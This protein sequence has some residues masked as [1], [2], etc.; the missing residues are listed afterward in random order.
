MKY[1]HF[2]KE[3]IKNNT[4]INYLK[5]IINIQSDQAFAEAIQIS[6]K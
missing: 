3:K 6:E 2:D 4:H 5:H 1:T